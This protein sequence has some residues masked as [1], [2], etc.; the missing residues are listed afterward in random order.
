MAKSP[1]HLF[2]PDSPVGPREE[3]RWASIFSSML[4]GQGSFW[5][6]GK[7]DE[8]VLGRPSVLQSLTSPTISWLKGV[9]HLV[10]LRGVFLKTRVSVDKWHYILSVTRDSIKAGDIKGLIV[11]APPLWRLHVCHPCTGL[12]LCIC[13]W[14]VRIAHV[15]QN[16]HLAGCFWAWEMEARPG[17][18]ADQKEQSFSDPERGHLLISIT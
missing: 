12:L 2:R 3:S 13:I 6:P 11:W 14:I 16:Y 5:V 1:Q 17:V 10:G 18:Q 9:H 15:L 7:A 8:R 4:W